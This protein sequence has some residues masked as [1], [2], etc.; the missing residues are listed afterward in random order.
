MNN[1]WLRFN[2]SFGVK[3]EQIE[4]IGIL[5]GVERIEWGGTRMDLEDTTGIFE[6]V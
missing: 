4:A 5:T 6:N 3:E 2:F 1:V